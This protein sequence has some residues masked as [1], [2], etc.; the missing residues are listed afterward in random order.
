MPVLLYLKAFLRKRA[1]LLLSLF[2]AIL[3]L[4]I[5][6]GLFCQ[7][8]QNK[9]AE[10]ENALRSLPVTVVLSNIAGTQTD[11][12]EIPFYLAEY[13]TSGEYSYGGEIQPRAFSSYVKDVKM[14]TT[15]YYSL[16]SENMNRADT[17]PSSASPAWRQTA[18]S[19]RTSLILL[20]FSPGWVKAFLRQELP[21]V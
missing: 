21:L 12:L 18:R 10:R 3:I 4:L 17:I 8:I 19:A 9:L 2:F 13:F 5:T 6:Y 16:P 15:L 14:K 1:Y 20:R 11:H 7:M